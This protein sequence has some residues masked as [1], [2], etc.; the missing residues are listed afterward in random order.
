MRLWLVVCLVLGACGAPAPKHDVSPGDH[1]PAATISP[2]SGVALELAESRAAILSD[3]NYAL[4][5]R[6]P[7]D[8]AQQIELTQVLTFMLSETGRDLQ[9]DFREAADNLRTLEVNGTH[10]P[11]RHE[12]EH[13]V[14]PAEALVAGGNTVRIELI[15]G[16][17]SLNRNPDY[18]YTLFVPDRA[19]TAFPVFDQPNLKATYDLSLDLPASWR[20]LGNGPLKSVTETGGSDGQRASRRYTFARSDK[21][22]SYLFSFVAGEFEEITRT[23]DGREMTMFHRETDAAKV[24][25]NVDD[26]FQAH[27][28]ALAWLEDYTGIEYPFQKFDFALIPTF[29]YGGMENV[30]AIQY[31]AS[32]LFLDEDPS[33]PQRLNRANLIAHETAHMWFGD[34][35]TMD[36]FNDVWTKEVFANFMAA[37]IVNPGFPEIDHD[38]NFL[39]RSYPAAYAV[40]RTT[41]ANPIRQELPNLNEAGNLYGGIIYNK[42]PIM[43]RQLELLIGETLF[44]D[45]LREY[46]ATFANANATWP[47]LI[48]ILDARSDHDLKTWSDVWVNSAGRP[49]YV[50]N[51]ER[52]ALKQIDPS[53]AGR[54]WGQQFQSILPLK[55]KDAEQQ[56]ARI[57]SQTLLADARVL[58]PEDAILVNSDGAGYGLFPVD[59]PLVSN[60]WVNLGDLEK[61]A[62][63]INLYEQMLDGHAEVSPHSYFAFLQTRLNEPNELLLN[64][65]L[66]QVQRIYW[67]FLSDAQR[68]EYAGE[69]EGKL[70]A[71]IESPDLPPSTRKVYFR[72]LQ[73]LAIDEASHVRLRAILEQREMIS[74]ISLSSRER[75]NLASL[76][77]IKSPQDAD[78]ILG[79]HLDWLQSPDEKRRF[80]FIAP[81]LSADKSERDSFF[82][83]LHMANNRAIES[84]VVEAL[85]YLHHPQR[86]GETRDYIEDGLALMEEIQVTG[87][88][89]FPARWITQ[90]LQNH[91]SAEAADIVRA[92]LAERP[93]YN[94]QLRLKILQAADPIFRA[95]TLHSLA[96]KD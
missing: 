77:A 59:L 33:D 51:P 43:M 45:G 12:N 17:T 9:L 90:I 25:R 95:E 26:V 83:S 36:W 91:N 29:Q 85:G 1:G 27:A 72:A 50:F 62:Q 10:Y 20:A 19:R 74:G 18:L 93:N 40:D 57:D 66:G 42:A 70:W 68:T 39:L 2:V 53:G 75:S 7:A 47:D 31:R 73:D 21:L 46:L 80:E 89:F 78:E 28:D 13:L 81:A 54:I 65:M 24:A 58:Q 69:L 30:G 34:L 22:S 32:T 37:K 92:F 8:A 38:L 3:I 61:G 55:E 23:I 49:H 82:A 86:V 48:D 84:W 16:D 44:R 56:H 63:L 64:T 76:L 87:D 60:V 79:Q 6:I 41:G 94:A 14:L 11:V 96:A 67:S 15:A 35:V 71:Y 5:F 52:T 4:S 88:I